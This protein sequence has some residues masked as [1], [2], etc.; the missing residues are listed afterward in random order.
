[1]SRFK[2][3]NDELDINKVLKMNQ[4][5]STALL[6]DSDV[7]QTRSIADS[8]IESSI[9]LLRSLGKNKEIFEMSNEIKNKKEDRKLEHRPQLESWEELVAQ[10]NLHDPETVVLED[11]M[12][13]KEIQSTFKELDEINKQFSKKTSLVNKTDLA[14]LTIAT[15]LQV[16]KALIFPYIAE[17]FDYGKEFDPEE[18]LAHNDKSIE[19]THREANDKFRDKHIEKTWD[20]SLDKYFISD[21]SL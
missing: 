19:K 11:I 16:T 18:R 8:N 10:A 20:R 5:N 1:M 9:E 14:F 7:K 6:D 4:D 3:S 12:T 21:G 15:A 2:Y 17:K 13:E